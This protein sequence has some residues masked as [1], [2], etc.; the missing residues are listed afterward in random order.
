MTWLIMKETGLLALN[1][2][3]VK[4]TFKSFISDR[5][6]YPRAPAGD[7]NTRD[8]ACVIKIPID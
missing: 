1:G 4:D 7:K 8:D 6:K 3:K 2:P 5:S